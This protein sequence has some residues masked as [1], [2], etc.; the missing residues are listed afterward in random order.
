M[1]IGEAVRNGIVNNET[2]G[3]MIV[4]TY[5]FLISVGVSKEFIRFRQHLPTEMA[6]YAA[7]CWD[8][9]IF[10]SY[11]W[12]ECVGIADRSAFD[13]NAHS[14]AAKCDLT[15][16][17]VL[18][19]PIEKEVLAITKASGV[20]VMK[21]FA[22]EG[23]MVKEHIEALSQDELAALEADVKKGPKKLEID[24]KSFELKPEQLIFERKIAKI[25]VN[26]FTPGVIEPSF[27]IDRIFTT[28]LEHIYYVRKGGDG[29]DEKQTRAVLAFTPTAAPYKCVILP[30]DQRISRHDNYLGMMNEFR[31]EIALLGMSY[32]I[33][34]SGATIGRRY[35]RNDEIGIPFAVTFDFTTLEDST[36]TM[37]E[38]DS[39]DQIRVPLKDVGEII[40]NICIG[41]GTWNKTAAKYP[42]Q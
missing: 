33:D 23:K 15:Y 31:K 28:V 5:L 20:M 40:R 12:L 17:E 21:A 10:C 22:K 1:T 32:T 18:D 19:K 24:G 35:A 26:S 25:S 29:E 16:K 7:D 3:Y 38:R 14:A 2:L 9:E 11:G 13:L 36:V 37:R 27:G 39:C 4:R 42:K 30:L 41:E 6:H 34:E 8:A